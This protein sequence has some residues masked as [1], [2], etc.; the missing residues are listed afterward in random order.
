MLTR[1]S[2]SEWVCSAVAMGVSSRLAGDLEDAPIRRAPS[3][4]AWPES[5]SQV[6]QSERFERPDQHRII[7]GLRMGP[8]VCFLPPDFAPDRLIGTR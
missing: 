5:T 2:A 3:D 7:G 4:P 8:D 6:N 1:C